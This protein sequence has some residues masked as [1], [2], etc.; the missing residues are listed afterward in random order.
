M[1]PKVTYLNNGIESRTLKIWSKNLDKQALST[2]LH[3]GDN[4]CLSEAIV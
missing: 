2:Y 1:L 3:D 4:D